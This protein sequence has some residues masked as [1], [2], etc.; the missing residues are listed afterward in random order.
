MSSCYC[1]TLM[2]IQSHCTISCHAENTN[3]KNATEFFVCRKNW[4][5]LTGEERSLSEC[6]I[7]P[8]QKTKDKIHQI[9]LYFLKLLKSK[10]DCKIRKEKM[11]GLDYFLPWCTI[12]WQILRSGSAYDWA[13]FHERLADAVPRCRHE[14][15]PDRPSSTI[16]GSFLK[17]KEN[18]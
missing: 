15:G 4:A 7:R 13:P 2:K 16:L 18:D 8:T 11:F 10:D 14:L 12:L 9:E 1:Q 3:I 5:L 17:F 6:W